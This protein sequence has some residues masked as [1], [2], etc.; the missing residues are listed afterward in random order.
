MENK[1]IELLPIDFKANQKKVRELNRKMNRKKRATAIVINLLATLVVI[2]GVTLLFT[3]ST[4][5]QESAIE[6]C[7]STGNSENFCIENSY[8]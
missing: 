8:V 1:D 6:Q 5:M 7:V 4:Q 2:L 3:I